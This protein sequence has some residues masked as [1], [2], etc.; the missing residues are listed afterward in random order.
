[1]PTQHDGIGQA[2]NAPALCV[3]EK[4]VMM[5]DDSKETYQLKDTET[6]FH[7][8]ESGLT[9]TRDEKVEIGPGR[10]RRTVQ[11]I[12]SGGLIK[13]DSSAAEAGRGAKDKRNSEETNSTP[14]TGKISDDFPHA[15]ILSDNGVTTFGKLTKMSREELETLTG[16]GPQ[17]AD[18]IESA[19]GRTEE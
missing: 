11:M 18:D 10:G 9:V 17:F 6:S 4:G 5:K 13:V 16:I 8:D 3:A 12:K 2:A 15:K 7:D 19:L 1:M 14:K